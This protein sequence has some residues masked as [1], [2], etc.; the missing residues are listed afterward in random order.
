MSRR[1]SL[2]DVPRFDATVVSGAELHSIEVCLGSVRMVLI[3]LPAASAMTGL[4]CLIGLTWQIAYLGATAM[5]LLAGSLAWAALLNVR[6][7]E[8][9]LLRAARETEQGPRRAPNLVVISGR[10]P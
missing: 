5:A 8:T 2:S 9:I 7:I 10:R 1:E 3:A 6:M 4:A